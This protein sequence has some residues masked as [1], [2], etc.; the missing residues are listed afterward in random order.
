MTPKQTATLVSRAF[1]VW[2][3]YAAFTRLT[4]IPSLLNTYR[5][6][7]EIGSRP[8]PFRHYSPNPMLMSG[9]IVSLFG[10]V[11][12]IALAI[13]FYRCGP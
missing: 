4:V 9:G 1:C 7:S 11:I 6:M 12:D 8:E 10:L 3:A 5:I 13:L 2:F